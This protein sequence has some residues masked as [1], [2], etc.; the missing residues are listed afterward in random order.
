[1]NKSPSISNTFNAIHTYRIQARGSNLSQ[2]ANL[3]CF[4]N[5]ATCQSLHLMHNDTVYFILFYLQETSIL[6]LHYKQTQN[7]H[8]TYIKHTI[9]RCAQ[10]TAYSC[11]HPLKSNIYIHTILQVFT[12]I[13]YANLLWPPF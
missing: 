12:Q 5:K 3:S 6:C 11:T 4:K 9:K 1:M 2:L 7:I 8:K 13:Q 10:C